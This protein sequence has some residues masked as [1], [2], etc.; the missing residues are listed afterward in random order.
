MLGG[1]WLIGSLLVTE[2]ADEVF[3]LLQLG[4]QLALDK[5]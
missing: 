5:V 1:F 4:Q 3:S 2:C